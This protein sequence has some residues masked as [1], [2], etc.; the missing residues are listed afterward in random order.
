M[1]K[2]ILIIISFLV[3][4]NIAFAVQYN[5]CSQVPSAQLEGK[6]CVEVSDCGF[7]SENR[8]YLL[9]QD[10]SDP[11]SCFFLGDEAWLDLNEH[12]VTFLDGEYSHIPN[13]GFEEGASGWD[14][15]GA[16]GYRIANTYDEMPLVG[17]KIIWLPAGSTI[18]SDW[19]YLPI[20]DRRYRAMVVEVGPS[21]TT[22][23]EVEN[24]N[25]QIVHTCSRSRYEGGGTI[26]CV[27]SGEP[28][29]NYRLRIHTTGNHYFDE[30]DIR[31]TYDVGVGVT[32]RVKSDSGYFPDYE[33]TQIPIINGDSTNKIM[34]GNIVAGFENIYTYG[35]YSV[36]AGVVSDRELYVDKVHIKNQGIYATTFHNLDT[37]SYTT[38]SVFETNMPW[39]INR[40]S[41]REVSLAIAGNSEFSNNV[42]LGGQG[43]ITVGGP[44]VLIHDNLLRN[45]QTVTNHYT[46][47]NY[48]SS[49]GNY[50]VKVYDNNFQPFQGG[51]L[52]MSTGTNRWEVYGNIFNITA[53]PCSAE[54][55]DSEFTTNA[56]R[57]TDYNRN[58]SNPDDVP[59]GAH[60]NKIYDNEFYLLGADYS[61][62]Y[63]ACRA[64]VNGI[65]FS[66][67]FPDNEI[68][69]NYFESISVAGPPSFSTPIYIGASG[70]DGHWFNNTIKTNDKAIWVG[71]PYGGMINNHFEN[72]ILERIPNTYYNVPDESAAIMSG[73]WAT[74]ETNRALDVYFI[75][76]HFLN[77]FDSDSYYIYPGSPYA[78]YKQWYVTINVETG[79]GQEITEA[80]V[81]LSSPEQTYSGSTQNGQVFFKVTEYFTANAGKTD[82]SPYQLTVTYGGDTYTDSNF[83]VDQEIYETV[84]LDLSGMTMSNIECEYDGAFQD[85]TNIQFGDTITRT[86]V[87]CVDS[88]G[89]ANSASFT[90][91]N[92][93]DDQVF[94]S[95]SGVK[96][97]NTFTYDV[98]P[99]KRLEDSGDYA[100]EVVCIDNENKVARN[101]ISWNF[102]YGTL[103]ANHVA[104][105]TGYET[106]QGG[107]FAYTTSLSCSGGECGDIS[108]IL[109][110]LVTSA[111]TFGSGGDYSGSNIVKDTYLYSNSGS[112]DTNFASSE[113]LRIY[114]TGNANYHAKALIWFDVD[115]ANLNQA[116]IID[117]CVL[118][119]HSDTAV[120]ADVNV[121]RGINDNWADTVT[122]TT[123][124]DYDGSNPW[125]AGEGVHSQ[126]HDSTI[127]DTITTG[128]GQAWYEFDV[129]DACRGWIQ[130]TYQNYGLWIDK[131]EDN[132]ASFTFSSNDNSNANYRPQLVM[133]VATYAKG[134]V[135][136]NSGSPFFTSS[137][138]PQTCLDMI[139]GETCDTTWT[140]HTT[141]DTGN[142]TFFVMYEPDDS[143]INLAESDQ[144][145]ISISGNACQIPY[146]SAPACDG[147]I[148]LGEL[149]NTING[150]Y[151]NAISMNQLIF[152][153]KNW[154]MNS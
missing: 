99:D 143:R 18:V 83:I 81:H 72:N 92:V 5:S 13:G 147:R 89:T 124:N 22:T 79:S 130:G 3:L 61:D 60:D 112:V 31:P 145:L 87:N 133:N 111:I 120:V 119:L 84:T 21:S 135:P 71:S 7:L 136:E 53:A 146:D 49:G 93:D 59:G 47:N 64:L 94:F 152:N 138:N 52:L 123:W 68:Y 125:S 70:G 4:I 2:F 24:Q 77:G 140:V 50:N 76:N 19:V 35:I 126:S 90:L 96:S 141:D 10:V 91:T 12:T 128:G 63:P 54:Y 69:D 109:D 51:G 30:A 46:I 23:I 149:I 28:A 29:G 55:I 150:W 82:Y 36:M 80:Q 44:N 39:V 48:A 85:C 88:D 26:N 118:R 66:V 40:E 75:N 41:L 37:K 153:I 110:P 95:G 97:G 100:F 122:T 38:N 132:V 8:Y 33:G 144:I 25:N 105:N 1:K 142:Y 148:D 106:G 134:V 115:A 17:E 34:N 73:D 127:L 151:L 137:Q 131:T 78:F 15:S 16:S 98:S 154:K 102:D 74:H 43:Q 139:S 65:F 11:M 107:T 129:T 45:N 62:R 116:T 114:R 104:P 117:S 56:I 32:D 101:T 67:G 113:T 108:A 121:Y 20:A 27:F 9:T 103:N 57:I 14:L 6:Q 86:R 42:V 58:P